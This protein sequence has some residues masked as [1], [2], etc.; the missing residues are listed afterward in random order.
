M[1]GTRIG[2]KEVQIPFCAN[3]MIEYVKIPTESTN[4][5]LELISK[6]NNSA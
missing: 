3:D 1:K 6:F 4:M 5:S 2:I